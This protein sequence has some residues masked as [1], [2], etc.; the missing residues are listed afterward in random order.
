MTAPYPDSDPALLG[1]DVPAAGYTVPPPPPPPDAALGALTYNGWWQ[2]GTWIVRQ[3]WRQLAL[4]QVIGM[5]L[6]LGAQTPVV[7]LLTL[8]TDDLARAAGT[9]AE[10]PDISQFYGLFGYGLLAILASVV[11][12]AAVTVAT[13]HVGASIVV[14]GT[15]S[16]GGAVR[17][18]LR[19]AFPVIGW[20]LLAVPIYLVA[21]CACVVPVIYVAA[22][23]TVLPVVVAVERNGAIGRCFSLFHADLGA[24]IA[25]IATIG[26]MVIGAAFV[27][28][29]IGT[30]VES[31]V[32]A[33]AAGDN[34]LIAGAVVA[35][36]IS[37]VFTGALAVFVAPLTLSAYLDLR[38]LLL[39]PVT[40][41]ELV[42]GLRLPPQRSH[43]A[44]HVG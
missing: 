6:Q 34:G 28:N 1:G 3:G 21:V 12:T 18:G 27:G 9:G 36:L 32:T 44:D 19:R 40:A 14:G 23:F 31:G 22:V 41:T 24:S 33:A 43:L 26:G 10:P 39:Q 37:T 4:L 16:F 25:R 29:V 11:A 30:L 2:R 42:D 35:V 8:R 38:A 20:Q 7:V 15:P 5:V 17:L 13:V